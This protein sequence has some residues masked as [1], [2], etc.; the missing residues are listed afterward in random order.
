MDLDDFESAIAQLP[1]EDE[2]AQVSSQSA[3]DAVEYIDAQWYTFVN[4]RGRW[5]DLIGDYAGSEPFV[6]DGEAL[7]DMILDDPLLALGRENDVSFQSVHAVYTLERILHDISKRSDS[8]EVVFWHERRFFSLHYGKSDYASCS[9]SLARIILYNHL[10]SLNIPVHTFSNLSDPEWKVYQRLKKPMFVMTNDGGVVE[11]STSEP[12]T[13]R[14]LLQRVFLYSL[15]A[16]GVSVTILHGAEYRDSKIMSFVYEQRLDSS[17]RSRFKEDFWSSVKNAEEFLTEHET[18]VRKGLSLQPLAT[19]TSQD[20]VDLPTHLLETLSATESSF[21]KQH[22]GL[23]CIFVAHMLCVPHIDLKDRA[24]PSVPLPDQL[25]VLLT[26]IFLPKMFLALENVAS[27]TSLDGRVFGTLLDAVLRSQDADLS[28]LLGTGIASELDSLWKTQKLPTPEL[29]NLRR[30][31]PPVQALQQMAG[32]ERP[33]L[34]LLPF[35]HPLFDEELAAIHIEAEETSEEDEE[36]ASHL[37]FNTLYSDTQHWHNP[38]RAILPAHLGGTDSV[39]PMTEWQRKKQLRSE[40]RFMSKLQWQ[41]ETLTGA[42]GTPLQQMVIPSAAQGKKA[43]SATPTPRAES[44]SRPGSAPN[45]RPGTPLGKGGKKGKKETLSSADKI[46][47]ANHAKKQAKEDDSN[48]AWWKEQL[49]NIEDRPTSSKI[50]AI[51]NLMRNKRTKEGWLSVEIRLYRVHLEFTRWIDDSQ[52]E[53]PPTRDRSTT[54]LMVMI[55]DLYES[56]E[57]FPTAAKY[58]AM[59]LIALGFADY[60]EAFEDGAVVVNDDRSL[61]FE[62]V[63]LVKSKS[64]HAVHKWMAIREDPVVWQLRLFGEFMDR[65]MDSASDPRVSFKPDAWQ[66]KVLDCLDRNESV[67]VAAPTSAGKTFISYYAMERLLRTSDD[68]VLVYV[69]PTKALVSQ[70]AAEVYARFRKELGSKACWAIHTRDYRVHNPQNCQILV[71]VPEMLATMLLSPPLARTWT[72]RIKRIILDEIHTIGQQEGGAVWEQIIL[73]APCPLI[74]LSATIGEPEKF[75]AWLASV[76]KAHGFKHTF[77]Y[78]PHRYSHLRKFNYLLQAEDKPA[79]L[80]SL[81]EYKRTDRMRFVHPISMLSFGARRLPPDFSL[82]SADCLSLYQ[83]FESFKERLEFDVSGLDPTNF[84]ANQK[85][86]LLKQKDILRYE[87]ALTDKVSEM[88]DSTDPQDQNSVLNSIIEK[89]SDPITQ[90]VDQQ[91]V[92]DAG[93]FFANLITLISDLHASGDLPALL[94][95]FDRKVCEKMAQ[96]ILSVLEEAESKWRDTSPEWKRKIKQWEIWVSKAK[97]RERQAG[98]LKKV[99]KD[100]DA[101]PAAEADTSWEASFNPDDPSPQFSFAGMSPAFTKE[102]LEDEIQSLARWSSAPEW[103]LKALRRGVGVHHSGMNKHYRTLVESLYRSG[104]LRVVIATGTLALGINAPTKTS[105]FCGDSPYL[106]ALMYRQCAGR[107]GRR[108]FDLLGKVVFYGLPMDR[109]QRLVLSKLPSL[110]GNFPLTSTMV[111][112]LFNLLQG[113]NDAPVARDAIRSLLRLPHISF[114]SEVGREQILHHIRFSIDYLRR[115]G[116]LDAEGNPVNL[117]G[118]AAHLY[119]T[120]PSNLALVAL[121]RHGVIHRI[122]NQSSLI[123]AKRDLM[124]LLSHLFGRRY[125]PKAYAS[126]KFLQNIVRKSPSTVVLPPLSDDARRVLLRHEDHIKRVFTGYAVAYV[127]HHAEALGQDTKLPFSG[128]SL[129]PGSTDLTPSPFTE[130]LRRTAISTVARSPFVAT[131][132][133]GDEFGSV[134][135]LTETSR[136]G[137]HLNEYAIPSMRQFTSVPGQDNDEFAL[138]AYLL[139]FYMHGQ[140]AALKAANGIR[141]G[142]MWYVLQDFSLTLKSIRTGLVQLLQKASAAAPSDEMSEI[143]SGYGTLDPAE[144]DP[145]IEGPEQG[146]FKRPSGVSDRD[147]RVYEVVNGVTAEF[148]EKFRAMWA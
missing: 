58:L 137:L 70:I 73:L 57:L 87:K 110:G 107:A 86:S 2:P 37:E 79:H 128:K 94:F 99:K 105:V 42:L 142:E 61:C 100:E 134:Q 1:L 104:Y 16:Q 50:V 8:F 22:S 96:A 38:K 140:T 113:S 138:N 84:F 13:A 65:S 85:G 97:E 5:M 3:K 67:L 116:L 20:D 66:R 18:R 133:H 125:L 17:P 35:S 60:I 74:G 71:T 33:P 14:I 23:L 53:S 52:R 15:L 120:E 82:E 126:P 103:A 117:F 29:A 27:T 89:V 24:R 80:S 11:E 12:A 91:Y 31:F 143:D 40:Q 139:D 115:A 63:K 130:Q 41:A 28:S 46:R 51:E 131:S 10:K 30:S 147:W 7:I 111:L 19:A 119:Y 109:C 136:D 145:D 45:S 64:G 68:D 108:G 39:G 135:E 78:H 72:P 43:R 48:I 144:A 49:A 25:A 26:S 92:P 75:N 34:S 44:S 4:R 93:Q 83:A 122:C 146:D 101:P 69:A 55:K 88:I 62:F 123:T 76:Q 32:S 21:I 81:Q 98:R 112:R 95:N 9:R 47:L 59:S 141:D 127:A 6:V 36:R 148:D 124:L 132:G 118:V 56:K 114:V 77:I 102:D 106:T 90:K 121:L 129:C 54:S